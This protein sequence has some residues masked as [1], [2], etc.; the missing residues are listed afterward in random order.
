[1]G[2]ALEGEVGNCL[3]ELPSERADVPVRKT[4]KFIFLDKFVQREA[5]PLEDD[6]VVVAVVEVLDI[7][8]DVVVVKGVVPTDF[9]DY[10][11]LGPRR[12]GVLWDRLYDLTLPKVTFI[13][14]FLPSKSPSTT[15]PNVPVPSRAVT[16]YL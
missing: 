13:A 2:V 7:P 3:E 9:L 11:A 8:D 6:A 15:L 12:V 5:E 4:Y 14:Y 16:L 10:G 1:M